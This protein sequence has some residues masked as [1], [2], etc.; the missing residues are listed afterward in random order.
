MAVHVEAEISVSPVPYQVI[1]SLSLMVS[2]R[3]N[4]DI[5]V[6]VDDFILRDGKN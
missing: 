2:M 1:I 3:N 6:F 4:P 5:G